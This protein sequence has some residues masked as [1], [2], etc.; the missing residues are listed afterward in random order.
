MEEIFRDRLRL[1]WS[2]RYAAWFIEEKVGR[3]ALKPL[4]IKDWDD[5][6][7]CARD[8][9]RPVMMIQPGSRMACWNCH[10]PIPVPICETAEARCAYCI[11]RNIEARY[12][13][14]YYPLGEVLIDHLRKID[15]EAQAGLRDRIAS[16]EAREERER[17]WVEESA[18]LESKEQLKDAFLDQ[19]PTAG[20]PSL[21]PDGWRH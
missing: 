3:A 16:E 4:R 10:L 12:M 2:V 15:P 8:G 21:V 20:F 18:S 7:I 17:R 19:L 9:Y 1:R 14:S 11:S 13:T 6:L 5:S